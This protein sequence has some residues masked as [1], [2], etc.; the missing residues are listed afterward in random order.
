MVRW[1][2][3][4]ILVFLFHP[5]FSDLYM[6]VCCHFGGE[7]Q[8]QFCEVKFLRISST[9]FNPLTPEFYFKF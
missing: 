1:E 7:F 8:Q 2:E 6:A 9:W 4:S 3:Q 5:V